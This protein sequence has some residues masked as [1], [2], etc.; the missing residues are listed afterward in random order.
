MI[1]IAT[2][3]TCQIVRQDFPC[4]ALSRDELGESDRDISEFENLSVGTDG[5]RFK[6]QP[7]T[8]KVLP[9]GK[10]L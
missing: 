9:H 7:Q 5:G 3:M 2:W 10:C 4:E 6:V 8:S 1:G